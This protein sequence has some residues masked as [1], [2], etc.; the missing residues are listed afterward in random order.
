MIFS[1][2]SALLIPQSPVEL[3][4]SVL[5][6]TLYIM[7]HQD[8]VLS[9]SDFEPMHQFPFHAHSKLE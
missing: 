7:E 2:P 3:H 1:Y 8:F 4:G 5:P 9:V 6:T